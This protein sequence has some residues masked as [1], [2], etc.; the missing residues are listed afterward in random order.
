MRPPPRS[1]S[2][3][4]ERPIPGLVLAICAASLSSKPSSQG[5]IFAFESAPWIPSAVESVCSATKPPLHQPPHT[6]NKK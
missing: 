3:A 6:P 4:A 1:C 2:F 5:H